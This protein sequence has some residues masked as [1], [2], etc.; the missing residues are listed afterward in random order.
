LNTLITGGTGFI[1]RQLVERLGGGDIVTRDPAKAAAHSW[2]AGTKFIAWRD[3]RTPLELPPNYQPDAVVNLMGESIASRRWNSEF[4][5][6]LRSSR[7]AGTQQL[8]AGLLASGRLPRVMVSASAI[9]YYGDRGDEVLTESATPGDDFLARLSIDWEAATR[10]LREAGVRVVQL[11]I[12]IVLGRDGGALEKMLPLF[13]WGLGGRLGNGRQW[14]PWIHER[15]VV[16]LIAWLLSNDQISGPVNAVAPGIVTNRE[17]TRELA[18][19]LK[20]PAFLPAP[21]FG[22]RLAIGEFA[23]SLLASSR[24]VPKVASEGGYA[25]CFPNLPEALQDVVS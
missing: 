2:P 9:G 20:R 14:F 8:V 7:I 10:P 13:R 17:F 11:R 4:K 16:E 21:R 22:L 5:E 18:K 3:Q 1:G 19:Q 15:D 12:G 23:D 25:F 24:V 6:R